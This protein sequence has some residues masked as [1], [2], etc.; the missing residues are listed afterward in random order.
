LLPVRVPLE[1]VKNL[2]SSMVDYIAFESD[3][4]WHLV[5]RISVLDALQTLDFGPQLWLVFIDDIAVMDLSLTLGSNVVPLI[6][7][8]SSLESMW[9]WF[10][11]TGSVEV[12]VV[13][14]D[15]SF[16]RVS[17]HR[18]DQFLLKSD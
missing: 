7:E 16:R 8:P 15:S 10:Q 3:G 11:K 12:L 6:D 14:S 17:R 5:H 13:L 18:L 9:H 4:E 2:A 1:Q